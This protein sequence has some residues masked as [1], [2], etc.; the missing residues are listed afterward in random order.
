MIRVNL[1][2]I[3]FA[4][5]AIPFAAG[6]ITFTPAAQAADNFVPEHTLEAE[7]NA[8][9]NGAESIAETVVMSKDG[10]LM[11]VDDVFLDTTTDVAQ[12]FAGRTRPDGRYYACD[13]TEKE[14]KSLRVT[15]RYNAYTRESVS[16]GHVSDKA[17]YRIPTLEESMSQLKG[18]NDVFG[19]DISLYIDVKEPAFFRNESLDILS[20]AIDTMTRYCYNYRGSKATLAIFDDMSVVRSVELGWV[21]GLES[22]ATVARAR[23]GEAVLPER[24]VAQVNY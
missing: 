10:V 17:T 2:T 15:E 6:A 20:A 13:F 24:L 9:M 7:A 19:R 5:L 18:L 4:A 1:K 3:L 21:G 22:E 23:Q 11:V 12:K 8:Y 14:L 16:E